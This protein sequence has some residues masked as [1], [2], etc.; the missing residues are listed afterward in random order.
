MFRFF[1]Q[2]VRLIYFLYMSLK[3]FTHTHTHTQGSKTTFWYKDFFFIYRAQPHKWPMLKRCTESY[4]CRLHKN[5]KYYFKRS[6]MFNLIV[7]DFPNM[8]LRREWRLKIL[9]V[10]HSKHTSYHYKNQSHNAVQ[11]NNFSLFWNL[12]NIQGVPGG[13]WNTSGVCSLC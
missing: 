11:G 1:K 3:N 10:P 6:L 4:N 2:L 8:H 12:H 13:M 9:F 7:H 5:A